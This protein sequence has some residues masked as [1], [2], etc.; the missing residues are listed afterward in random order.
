MI[1]YQSS[2]PYVEQVGA[3]LECCGPM[4]ELVYRTYTDDQISSTVR[5]PS[6]ELVDSLSNKIDKEKFVKIYNEV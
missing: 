1:F 5:D 6:T 2:L 4:L 3:L